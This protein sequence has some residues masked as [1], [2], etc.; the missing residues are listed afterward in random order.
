VNSSSIHKISKPRSGAVPDNAQRI[1]DGVSA[2]IDAM[3]VRHQAKAAAGYQALQLHHNRNENIRR[4][5]VALIATAWQKG[6]ES[7][8]ETGR[9]LIT[10]KTEIGTDA[11]A[12]MTESELP[13]GARTAERLMAVASNRILSNPTHVSQLPPSWGTLYELT[14]LDD[15]VLLEKIEAGEITPKLERKDVITM[16]YRAALPATVVTTSPATNQTITTSSSASAPRV[17]RRS[18]PSET[19]EG[20]VEDEIEDPQNYRT[21]FLLRADQAVRFAVYSGPITKEIVAAADAVAAT[22]QKLAQKLRGGK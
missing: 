1:M 17:T 19:D 11:F 8:I 10:A 14:Q 7:I 4:Q 20:S 12:T 5:H 13:F 21:A 6:V 3:V 15:A 16:K 18:R 9:L 2:G 22:W